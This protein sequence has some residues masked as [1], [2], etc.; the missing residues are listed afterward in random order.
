M[1]EA[2]YPLAGG[3]ALRTASL[4]EY[5]A[6]RAAVD[7]IVFREPGC[8]HPA[9]RF[10]DGQARRID[11][12]DLPYHARHAAGR[13]LRN[14]VRML[15]GVPPLTDRFAG[16]GGRIAGLLRGRRYDLA[17]I[18]HSWC[19]P[20]WEQ[21][22]PVSARTVLNLHNVDSVLHR[23]CAAAARG[24]EAFA[25]R[26]FQRASETLERR[27]LPHFSSLLAPSHEDA[28]AVRRVAPE[29]RVL[30]YPNSVPHVPLPDGQRAHVVVF[31]GNLEYHPNIEAVRHFRAEI[32]PQLRARWPEL[33][34]R[35][36]GKNPHAV[37]KY[38]AG[39][40]RIEVTGPVSD[41]VVELARAEV[42]VV[43][44][45]AGSG[46]RFKILEAWA[47]GTPVVSTSMG[48]E[49][50]PGRNGDDLLLADTP[51]KFHEAVTA[52]LANPSLRR[53]LAAAGRALF[54]RECT[55]E[56]AWTRLNF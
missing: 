18:E 40:P 19:A 3:G 46:T 6:R 9:G 21:V 52:L 56:S 20:Y 50:L 41:A 47:A 26:V 54:E 28:E 27:W 32:W 36:I 22:A 42:A 39:D 51:A 29:V 35:L 55:W 15:R 16:F 8:E 31:S 33:V 48:A 12:I 25:H 34:W 24:P 10:R 43:P 17:V 44:I 30:V 37:R 38:T 4:F 45:L 5:L 1:P 14:T 13:V 2:P 53:R 23:R 11:V 7:V 49:G